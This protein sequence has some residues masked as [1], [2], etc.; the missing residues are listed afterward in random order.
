MSNSHCCLASASGRFH[1]RLRI[2]SQIKCHKNIDTT[3]TKCQRDPAPQGNTTIAW[4][5]ALCLGWFVRW[6]VSVSSLRCGPVPRWGRVAC[7]VVNECIAAPRRAHRFP[8]KW[9]ACTAGDSVER[10]RRKVRSVRWGISVSWSVTLT[11]LR[12]PTQFGVVSMI[13]RNKL[14]FSTERIGPDLSRLRRGHQVSLERAEFP[15]GEAC[16]PRAVLVWRNDVTKNMNFVTPLTTDR[17]TYKLY[18]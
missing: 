6:R 16:L 12:E 10:C 15:R 7:W 13:H 9:C 14:I 2:H 11:T 17:N 8:W 18:T 1:I 5:L 3:L 4:L